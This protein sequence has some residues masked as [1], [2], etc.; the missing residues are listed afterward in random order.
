[1]ELKLNNLLNYNPW[2][3]K[4]FKF[5]VKKKPMFELQEA[6][7]S[8]EQLQLS[9]SILRPSKMWTMSNL[10]K[11]RVRNLKGEQ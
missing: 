3:T 2:L 11:I 6:T 9:Q 10:H 4:Y 1:M 5:E 7:P 8:H